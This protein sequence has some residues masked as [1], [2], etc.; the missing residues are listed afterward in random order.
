MKKQSTTTAP[1][2]SEAQ[3][4]QEFESPL[5]AIS[6]FRA[7]KTG[8]MDSSLRRELDAE[9]ESNPALREQALAVVMH[10]AARWGLW[11][12]KKRSSRKPESERRVEA[13]AAAEEE[14]AKR[15]ALFQRRIK[16]P[17][18][19]DEFFR[20]GGWGK[21]VVENGRAMF[22]FT[23]PA[24]ATTLLSCDSK[25]ADALE[26]RHQMPRTVSWDAGGRRHWLLSARCGVAEGNLC[27]AYGVASLNAWAPFDPDGMKPMQGIAPGPGG[28]LPAAPPRL[29][30]L[31]ALAAGSG[32]SNVDE[33]LLHDI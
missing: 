33:A 15:G 29:A 18:D 19:A 28:T 1:A 11:L 22:F 24:T 23:P 13:A 31:L 4:A 6:E 12:M 21:V 8:G 16:S 25:F 27:S 32:A 10:D 9:L 30:K 20:A 17:A 2:M 26:A 5:R 7:W 3:A 14:A